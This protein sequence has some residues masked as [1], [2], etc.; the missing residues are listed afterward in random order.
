M[1]GKN[2]MVTAAEEKVSSEPATPTVARPAEPSEFSD[3]HQASTVIA[4]GVSFDGNINSS[5]M[6]YIRGKVHG[7]IHADNSIVKIMRN[8]HVEGNI[9]AREAVIDGT[10]IGECHAEVIDIYEHGNINGEITYQTLAIKR[11]GVFIGTAETRPSAVIESN[12]IEM[13]NTLENLDDTE[14]ETSESEEAAR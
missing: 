10:L 7:N 1:F 13:S 9:F 11:G 12:V 14:I 8:G 3:T 6:V 2:K 4:D 5:G